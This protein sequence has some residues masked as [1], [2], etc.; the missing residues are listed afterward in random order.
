MGGARGWRRGGAWRRRDLLG[1][2]EGG[3]LFAAVRGKERRRGA[4][5]TAGGTTSG[6]LLPHGKPT[7][8]AASP[9]LIIS[10]WA[11]GS[12]RGRE[13][14]AARLCVPLTERAMSAL[15]HIQMFWDQATG[16]AKQL[17]P[18]KRK[19]FSKVWAKIRAEPCQEQQKNNLKRKQLKVVS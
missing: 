3:R 4:E 12:D 14:A 5:L 2:G 7:V 10:N 16:S 15:M 1:W 8:H 13:V 18:Q 17:Q 11:S 19:V 9:P 6:C